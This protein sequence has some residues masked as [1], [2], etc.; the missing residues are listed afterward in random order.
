MSKQITVKPDYS[1]YSRPE[2]IERVEALHGECER[3]KNRLKGL[4][5]FLFKA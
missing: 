3:Y 5:Y 2:L 1:S 4:F